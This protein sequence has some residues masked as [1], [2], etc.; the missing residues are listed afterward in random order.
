MDPFCRTSHHE[1]DRIESCTG[2]AH[3]NFSAEEMHYLYLT[4]VFRI[5]PL[6]FCVVKIFDLAR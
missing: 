4:N 5:I 6:H 3:Q 1:F 2:L